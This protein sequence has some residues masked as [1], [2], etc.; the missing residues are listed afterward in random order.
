MYE[1]LTRP[2]RDGYLIQIWDAV[3]VAH[4]FKERAPCTRSITLVLQFL[5]TVL[6]KNAKYY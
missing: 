3:W 2:A 4:S 1:L 5:F 6:F